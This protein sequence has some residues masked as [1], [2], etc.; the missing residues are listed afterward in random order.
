MRFQNEI[1]RCSTCRTR[2]CR[3][4]HL[5]SSNRASTWSSNFPK[6]RTTS[7]ATGTENPIKLWS[8]KLPYCA[9]IL[10][11]I[12]AL[13][14]N[15]GPRVF[16]IRGGLWNAD[17]HWEWPDRL[18]RRVQAIWADSRPK[19][20]WMRLN[21]WADNVVHSPGWSLIPCPQSCFH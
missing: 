4:S 17:Y 8:T 1:I 19:W 9:D 7:S 3:Q 15:G 18:S 20:V 10:F 12:V 14:P 13:C 5:D 16:Y 11:A 2:R 21:S 6:G